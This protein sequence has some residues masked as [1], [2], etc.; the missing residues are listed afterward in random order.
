MLP[1][2]RQSLCHQQS[3]SRISRNF[4]LTLAMGMTFGFSFAYLLLNVVNWEKMGFNGSTFFVPQP[5]H[6]D[7]NDDLHDPHDHHNLDSIKGPEDPV[8][9]HS[10]DEQFHKGLHF[11]ILFFINYYYFYCTIL[12]ILFDNYFFLPK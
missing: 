4:L 6:W 1:T 2:I 5:L 11:Y 12:S 8:S 9:F 7:H 3:N 10:H